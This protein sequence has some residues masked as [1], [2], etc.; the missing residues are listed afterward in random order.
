MSF[1]PIRRLVRKYR[2]LTGRVYVMTDPVRI[3]VYRFLHK[4]VIAVPPAASRIRAGDRAIGEFMRA[5]RKCFAPISAAVNAHVRRGERPLRVLD[6]GS[7]AGRVLQYFARDPVELYACDVDAAAIDHVRRSFPAVRSSVSLYRPPLS[8]EAGTF[9]VVYSVSV[10]THLAPDLQIPWLLEMERILVP[11]GLALLTTIGPF[12]YR[13]GSHL[14]AVTFSLDDLMRE[15][16]RH[17]SYTTPYL[18][19]G[20]LYG[21]AYHTPDYIRRTWSNY[22]DVLD[23]Q[24]GVVD[25][26]N[27]LVILRKKPR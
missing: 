12:G 13:R 7:G 24:E 10:W 1:Q 17:S 26:L 23:V 14:R 16:F 22:F 27:D 6:F 18:A 5:G 8:Y 21:A 9:D 3:S 19:G 11:G 20:P 4:D 15:G 25:D 2:A